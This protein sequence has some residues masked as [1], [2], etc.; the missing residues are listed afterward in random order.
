MKTFLQRFAGLVVGVL[1]GFDRLVFR[2]KLR[3]LYAPDGMDRFLASNSILFKHF[4]EYSK[5]VTREVIEAS[6]AQAERLGRPFE[7]LNAS[8]ISKEK[9][10]CEIAERDGV[11]E[12]LI[13]VF[14]AIEPCWSF[15][16]VGRN[17]LRI[18][19]A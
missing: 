4:K 11:R 5:T 3:Q 7:Y 15:K 17:K 12:G 16:L 10:A 18:S 9:R 8:T 14:K 19:L 2:G 6:V 1:S 13:C